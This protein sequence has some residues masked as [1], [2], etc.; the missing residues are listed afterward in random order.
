MA[1]FGTSKNARLREKARANYE[2][3]VEQ[4]KESSR[5]ARMSGVRMALK[6]RANIDTA[7]VQAALAT[8]ANEAAVIAAVIAGENPPEPDEANSCQLVKSGKG[9]IYTYI[10]QSYANRVF[11]IAAQYQTLKIDREKAIAKAQEILD[12]ICIELGLL[13]QFEVLRFLRD[14]SNDDD[15]QADEQLGRQE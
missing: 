12:E 10:P 2:H 6:C 9:H 7:F 14:E 5:A 11:S 13:A 3:A 4:S 15:N 1:W 8:E